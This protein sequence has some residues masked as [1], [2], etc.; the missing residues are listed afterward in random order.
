[1]PVYQDF[2][3]GIGAGIN[4]GVQGFVQ[5]QQKKRNDQLFE[6]ELADRMYQRTRQR[7]TD[8]QSGMHIL[9]PGET[10][11]FADIAQDVSSSLKLPAPVSLPA[12]DMNAASPPAATGSPSRATPLATNIPGHPS[13]RPA[14]TDPGA[15]FQAQMA[16]ALAGAGTAPAP[17]APPNALASALST[18]MAT[19]P[20]RGPRFEYGQGYY[21]D[22]QPAWNAADASR[23]QHQEDQFTPV[24]VQQMLAKQKRDQTVANLRR[25]GVSAERAEV[26]ADNPALAQD[27]PTIGKPVAVPK[28]ERIQKRIG[29]LV[30]GG[31]PLPQANAR[32]RIEFGET[33]PLAEH[34][35]ARL[36][37]VDHPT[38]DQGLPDPKLKFQSDQQ[39]KILDDFQR[40]TKDFHQVMGGWDVLQG[41]VKDPSLATPFAVTDAYARITNP[42]AIVRPTTMQM[43]HDMGSV[44]QRMEKFWSQNANGALPPDIMKDF[45]RT[46]YNIVA[47]HKLQYDQIRQKAILRGQQASADVSPLLEDYTL[48]DPSAPPPPKTGGDTSVNPFAGLIPKKP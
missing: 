31:M 19:P 36:F 38:R 35:A 42:G 47:Q 7:A 3:P 32:A 41:A 24:L 13:N 21:I 27:D 40:D 4:A 8:A 5:G 17:A 20:S 12:M 16:P 15:T 6:Q 43:I 22:H 23:A 28:D 46:L 34:K 39:N 10:V 48:N 18:T 11:P 2:G 44:G 14:S 33:D 30:A 37:D 29:E 26:I 25:A 1:M 45:Q 9:A